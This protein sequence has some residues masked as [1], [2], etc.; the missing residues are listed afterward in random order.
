M[1]GLGIGD[2]QM[3]PIS[4]PPSWTHAIVYTTTLTGP[5]IG[6]VHCPDFET[7]RVEDSPARPYMTSQE[8]Y[9]QVLRGLVDACDLIDFRVGSTVRGF[10]QTR[11]GCELVIESSTGEDETVLGAYALFA[12]GASSRARKWLGIQMVGQPELATV[13]DV[14]FD[15]DGLTEQIQE[16][17]APL[18]FVS[19]E[20]GVGVYQPIDAKTEWRCQ[21]FVPGGQ[22]DS[23]EPADWV[24]A[25]V[26]DESLDVRIRSVRPW[27][28]HSL[29]ADR[30][31]VGRAFLLGDAAHVLAPTGG[32]G[33][34]SGIQGAHNLVWKLA[35]VLKGWADARLLETYD[36]ERRAVTAVN[37][38][39][40]L[41]NNVNVGA[42]GMAYRNNGDVEGALRQAEL[43]GQFTGLD[44]GVRYADGAFT[45]DGTPVKTLQETV[46]A[47]DHSA[48]PG[49]RA[50]HVWLSRGD[51]TVSTLD[52]FDR[53]FC[54]L[55][56]KQGDQWIRAAIDLAEKYDIPVS[57]FA[58]NGA[59]S[60]LKGEGWAK[61]YGLDETG[62]VL[63]RP[64][65]HIGYRSKGNVED[66]AQ[67][68]ASALAACLCRNTL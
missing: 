50:P 3:S 52:L 58:V 9:E 7:I 27:T 11:D 15:V 10:S 35:G 1:R 16:R 56:G 38:E 54:L 19:S 28:M 67:T 42:I 62:A 40:A 29:M 18:L 8:K 51:Q 26:G 48:G 36:R 44:L 17:V 2:E 34:N 68:L 59:Q 53:G 63:V 23:I 64:D 4:L 20:V 6:R 66:H 45:R 33:M 30:F 12:D 25:T 47:Y 61:A 24:R 31:Q 60:G 32:F 41:R 37:A 46:T 5:E 21:I 39:T 57:A 43:Y 49:V 22:L 65:G 55:A 13:L 14:H